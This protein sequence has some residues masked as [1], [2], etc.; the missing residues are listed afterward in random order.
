MHINELSRILD[1][2]F[3]FH[4]ARSDCFAQLVVAMITVKTVN[5]TYLATAF[6]TESFPESCSK[7]IQR[8]F[9]FL[10]F[11]S[12]VAASMMIML[13]CL[14]NKKLSLALDRTK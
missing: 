12:Y 6:M 5:F 9:R 1:Q 10:E 3:N 7:R 4:K 8:F 13:F 2:Y 14:K 11:G